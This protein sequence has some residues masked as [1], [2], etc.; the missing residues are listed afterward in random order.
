MEDCWPGAGLTTSS[1]LPQNYET[2]TQALEQQV[3]SQKGELSRLQNELEQGK[4][5]RGRGLWAGWGALYCVLLDDLCALLSGHALIL[6][7]IRWA[8]IIIIIIIIIKRRSGINPIPPTVID[9]D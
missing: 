8:Q 3:S 9:R 4:E 2:Q 6:C 7:C 1:L 5:V